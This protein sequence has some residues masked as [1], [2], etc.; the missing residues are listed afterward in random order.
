MDTTEA[1]RDETTASTRTRR[2]NARNLPFSYRSPGQDSN[3][4]SRSL[5]STE[6]HSRFL[7]TLKRQEPP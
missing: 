3:A 7:F 6:S 5:M 2:I 4:D 1:G